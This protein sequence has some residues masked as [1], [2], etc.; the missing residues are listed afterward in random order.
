[1]STKKDERSLRTEGRHFDIP[2]TNTKA[3][4]GGRKGKTFIPS[5]NDTLNQVP[6]SITAGE[7]LPHI[8]EYSGLSLE[9]VPVKGLRSFLYGLFALLMVLVGWEVYTVLKSA[10]DVHWLLASG[11]AGLL[12]VVAG[13]SIR[14]LRGFVRDQEN[15]GA[16]EA[17]QKQAERLSEA[18]NVG[19]AKVFI[20]TLQVFYADK[21]QLVYFQ[22][23]IEKLPDYS[24][25]R[26]VVDHIE[27]VFLKPLD[28]EALRRISN[29]SLQTGAV[30]AASPWASLD[31]LLSLWRSVKMIDDIAQVYG[32][33]PSLVNRYKLL[34]LVVHQMAFVGASEIV[35]DQVMEEFG[36]STLTSM[37]SA[38]LG[39]GLG[40]GIYTARIGIAAMKVSR[41]IVF[42][43]ESQP[44]TKSIIIPMI[45][46]LKL[47]VRGFRG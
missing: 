3:K 39:Q 34:K 9:A 4:K 19:D 10:L 2:E 28:K 11:F 21:P 7:R 8:S 33:R 46:R 25:D 15:L 13:L 37:A 16:L 44:S 29:V 45:D 20:D 27:R 17:V 1:M 22:R 32:M 30:V 23:C 14:L 35:I 5:Q 36:S 38:R 47:M 18:C 24:N 31:M 6:E 40:A 26:E 41:P 43:K 12:V 42:I